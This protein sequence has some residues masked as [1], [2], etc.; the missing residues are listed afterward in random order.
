MIP[1]D[2]VCFMNQTGYGQAAMDYVFALDQSGK[3]DVRL[4][5]LHSITDQPFSKESLKKIKSLAS[6]PIDSNA[7]Q[8]FHSIPTMQRRVNKRLKKTIGFATFESF[9]PPNSWISILNMNDAAICPSQF[10]EKIFKNSKLNRPTFHIPHCID[11]NKWHPDVSPMYNYDKFSFLFVG[12]WRRR[13]GWDIL[14]EAWLKAFDASDNVQLVIKTDKI[15]KA[16]SD[17][18]VYLKK[19]KKVSA[20]ILFEKNIIKEDLMPSF[21]KSFNCLVSPNLGEGFG[22]TPVQAMSVDV[23]VIVTNFSGC[24]DYATKDRCILL[25]PKGFLHRDNMDNIHQFSQQK[26]PRITIE[27]ISDSMKY[28]VDN[29]SSVQLLSKNANNYVKNEYNYEKCVKNFDHMMESLY[30]VL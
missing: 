16:Q 1:I 2:Y 20:P 13:K 6:K 19:S 5:I 24:K 9:S 30:G 29:Y 23:P 10:N 25:N 18:N 17:V 28:C 27:S 3:Y 22:L 4:N 11:F 15:E 14:L 21:Y 12:T 8:I 26:W 7:I